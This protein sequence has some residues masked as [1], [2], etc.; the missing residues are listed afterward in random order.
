MRDTFGPNV[1]R[2][3]A[4]L[5]RTLGKSR[6]LNPSDLLLYH[7]LLCFVRAYP[8]D[9]SLEK[10]A[11]RELLAFGKRVTD[12]KRLT[13]DRKGRRLDDSGIESTTTCYQFNYDMTRHLSAKYSQEPPRQLGLKLC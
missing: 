2:E 13:R 11:E 10:L 12:Y 6:I 8:D 1:A 9:P 3:R 4:S 5:I 7:D